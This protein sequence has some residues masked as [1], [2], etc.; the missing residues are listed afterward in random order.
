M[1]IPL[2]YARVGVLA[3]WAALFVDEFLPSLLHEWMAKGLVI[4]GIAALLLIAH[5]PVGEDLVP[6]RRKRLFVNLA[7]AFLVVAV[8][9]NILLEPMAL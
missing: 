3:N 7:I 8:L 2:E 6:L 1:K 9:R 4:T 5:C